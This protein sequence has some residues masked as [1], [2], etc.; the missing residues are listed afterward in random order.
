MP[1]FEYSLGT[2]VVP[3]FIMKELFSARKKN[4]KGKCYLYRPWL[5]WSWRWSKHRVEYLHKVIYSGRGYFLQG[6]NRHQSQMLLDV[7][8]SRRTR[9][10]R[11]KEEDQDHR[12]LPEAMVMKEFS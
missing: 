8:W 5:C 1:F 6:E 4:T 2:L 7:T 3:F 12:V 9:P 10:Q 11:E